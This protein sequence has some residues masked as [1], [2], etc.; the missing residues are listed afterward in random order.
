MESR[1]LLVLYG[2]QTGT[3]QDIAE[4]L[5]RQA[6]NIYFTAR[7]TPMDD[8]RLA[9]LIEEQIVVFVCSTTGQG[10]EPDN[11]K[12]FWRFLL[13]KNLPSNC[14]SGLL[15]AVLG[16]GDSSYIKFNFAAKKLHKRLLQ[17]GASP[18]LSL[19]LADDNHD[20]GVDAVV[21][22]WM[23]SLWD[24]LLQEYPLPDGVQRITTMT[25]SPK[26]TVEVVG[27]DSIVNFK[28]AGIQKTDLITVGQTPNSSHPFMAT[29]IC[30]ERVTA[31]NHFQD[32]R[33]IKLDITNS[34]ISYN[35]GDV[36]MVQP[37][38]LHETVEDFF[39][40]IN[41]SPE[42]YLVLKQCDSDIPLPHLVQSGSSVKDW[43]KR[44]FD[45]QAV[46]R[47]YFFEILHYFASDELE[48]EKLL[49]FLSVEGQRELYNYCNSYRRTSLEV[50]QDFHNTAD[51]I[52]LDYLFDLF[53]PIKPRAFS[54][55]SSSL[56]SPTEIE[57]LV[58]VVT[59][60]TK[61][62][63]RRQGLC[64]TWLSTLT[65]GNQVPIWV[66]KGSIVFPKES[67]IPVIMVG[68]G[69]GC[70][71]FRAFLLQ[72]CYQNIGGNYLFFG[73][74]NKEGDFFFSDEWLLMEDKGLLKL[75]AAF[76]RDQSQKM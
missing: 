47:R 12:T 33:L 32:V 64:S 37:Y 55:A 31:I 50:L 35:T 72:R 48:R 44:Y 28:K 69:T 67:N 43:V 16:L 62:V 36:L 27:K 19:A 17:L 2:S 53:S 38:N 11:M 8:Y 61:L 24:S 25:L 20:L 23:E 7:V 14:L 49:E 15:F 1:K 65:L 74:R 73:C 13:R 75:F 26:Y 46:P 9:Q 29:V 22:P 40:I 57:V 59:Y 5:G 10:E 76:S 42:S 68:P 34:G 58:A 56:I 6:K 30:N 70:A 71:P 52:S 3:A 45:I 4:R 51:N 41:L 54:I 60:K 39:K 21:I 18:M 66:K 63:K